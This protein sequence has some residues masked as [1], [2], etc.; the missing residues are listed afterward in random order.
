[1]VNSDKKLKCGTA[2]ERSMNKK[3]ADQVCDGAKKRLMDAV[4][5]EIEDKGYTNSEVCSM[6]CVPSSRVKDLKE[7]RGDG[8]QFETLLRMAITLKLDVEITAIWNRDVIKAR[9][10]IS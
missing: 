10:K 8:F 1:M 3:S 6:T 4:V 7:K 2:L 5:A 9:V